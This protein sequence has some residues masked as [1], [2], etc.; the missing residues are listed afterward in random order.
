MTALAPSPRIARPTSGG[1]VRP[2]APT[3]GDSVAQRVRE[4]IDALALT[5][6]GWFDGGGVGPTQEAL[7]AA[8][9]VLP[10]LI[11]EG[12]FPRP[13]VFPTPA[14]GIKAEWRL[15]RWIVDLFFSREDGLIDASATN[16]DTAVVRQRRFSPDDIGPLGLWLEGL[17]QS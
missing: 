8:R 9:S 6:D 1:S 2:V 3:Q 14:G 12:D 10:T 11:A 16:R 4:R 7:S 13:G 17:G 5:S 15:G